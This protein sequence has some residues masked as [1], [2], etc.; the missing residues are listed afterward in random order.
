MTQD[1]FVCFQPAP[2]PE[3]Y[4]VEPRRFLAG[5]Y[6]G[7]GD[8]ESARLRVSGLLDAG[9]QVFVDLTEP[10]VVQ[11]YTIWLAGRAEHIRLPIPDFG[12]PSFVLMARILD[13][14]DQALVARRPVYLHCWGGLGRTGTVVGCYG[15]RR[16]MSGEEAL[17]HLDKLRQGTS[18]AH[19]PSPETEAQRRLVLSWCE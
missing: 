10:G 3:M 6:P 17:R 1:D 14:L 11:P 4:W 15:V 13:A 18:L 8:A 9:I 19:H 5:S 16:G 2:F 7:F 12:V